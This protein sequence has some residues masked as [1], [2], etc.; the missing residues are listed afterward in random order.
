MIQSVMP[1]AL[2]YRPRIAVL[3]GRYRA[4]AKEHDATYLDL[5][6]ALSDGNG[7]LRPDFSLD[8]LHLNGAGYRA[9][10]GE[11]GPYVRG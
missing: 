10:V 6:P 2:K 8:K 4:L 7:A 5:W 1:R 11:L 3:N 9:W